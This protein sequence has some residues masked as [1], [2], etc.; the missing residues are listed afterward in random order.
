LVE[1]VSAWEEM[2]TGEIAE[3]ERLI[4]AFNGEAGI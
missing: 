2:F 3:S 4:S 1:S